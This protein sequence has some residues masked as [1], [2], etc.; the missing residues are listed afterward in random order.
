MPPNDDDENP[1]DFDTKQPLPRRQGQNEKYRE[2]SIVDDI[3]DEAADA[4]L[5]GC[6]LRPFIWLVTLPFRL[7]WRIIEGIFD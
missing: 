2:E 1:Y 5:E 6:L 4:V 7:I 3:A